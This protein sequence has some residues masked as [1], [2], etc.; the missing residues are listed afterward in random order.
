MKSSSYLIKLLASQETYFPAFLVVISAYSFLCCLLTRFIVGDA[1]V[2]I[3]F[4]AFFIGA[5]LIAVGMRV[6]N[7]WTYNQINKDE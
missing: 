2:N 7:T 6:V 5:V 1:Q 3:F 4:A